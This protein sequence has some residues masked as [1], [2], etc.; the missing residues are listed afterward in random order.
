MK[1]SKRDRDSAFFSS[2]QRASTL[3]NRYFLL[4]IVISCAINFGNFFIGAA[5]SYWVI[6]MGGTNATFGVI[7]GL[8]SLLIMVARPITG[9]LADHGDRRKTFI[10]SVVVYVSSMFLMLIS[11]FFGLF[12][13]LRLIQGAG[14]GG[15]TTIVTTSSYDYIPSSK[16]DKGIGYIALFS[17]I[18]T[19]LTPALSISTYNSSGP[20][21]LVVW[22]AVATVIGVALSYLITFRT[23]KEPKKFRIKE[24]FDYKVLFEKRSMKP[25][26]VMALSVNLVMGANTFVVLYGRQI[27]I[28]NPGWFSSVSAVVLIFVRIILDRIKTNEMFP[29]KRVYLAYVSLIAGLVCLALCKN[30]VMYFIAAFF[31]AIAFGILFPAFTSMIIKAAPASRRGAA[32]ST[33]GVAADVG[34]I[35]GSTVGGFVVQALGYSAL[36]LI[37]IVPVILCCLYY[38]FFIDGKYKAWEQTAQAESEQP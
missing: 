23:P 4:I 29:R 21:P 32:T 1:I 27:G 3:W 31:W 8:Y 36:Y 12:V 26:I 20:T 13:A 15:A 9:W 10:A 25:A 6:D 19:A 24:I 28:Q 18:I 5:F 33:A 14:V 30:L 16:L 7:H 35:L 37:V 11:P 22:S 17:S 2:D 38:R 34:M